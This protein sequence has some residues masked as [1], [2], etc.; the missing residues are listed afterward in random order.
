MK[1]TVSVLLILIIV[2]SAVGCKSKT[3]EMTVSSDSLTVYFFDVGQADSSLLIFPGGTTMLIDAGNEADGEEI[4]DFM[5]DLGIKTVDYFVLTHPHEDHIGGAEDIF[6]EFDILTVCLPN[7]PTEFEPDTA[8]F[9]ELNQN[10]EKE[11]CRELKLNADTVIVEKESYN[12]TSVGPSDKAVFS[13]MNDWSLNLKV[14]C[15][16]NTILFVGDSEKP[17]ELDM[18]AER[19][20]LDADILKVG[21][22]GSGNSSTEAFLNA[23]TPQVSVISVGANNSYNHPHDDALKRLTDSGSKVLRTD[24]VGTVIAHCYDGGFNI[25]TDS[26]ICLDGNKRS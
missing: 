24:T 22:H 1:R 26:E 12:V 25:E 3:P 11:K 17:A 4:A 19:Q 9:E 23:V 6:K 5:S 14:V 2:L 20:N 10:I 13:D 21:H 15:F 16:T 18:L 7:I 8:I